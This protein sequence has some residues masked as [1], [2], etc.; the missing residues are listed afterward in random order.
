MSFLKLNAVSM[1]ACAVV[2]AQIIRAITF[3]FFGRQLGSD[4]A[5]KVRFIRIALC[6]GV[7][8]AVL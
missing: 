5:L 2:Y 7:A 4:M 1:I 8:I 6:I 3:A